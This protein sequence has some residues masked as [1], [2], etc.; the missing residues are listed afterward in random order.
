MTETYTEYGCYIEATTATVLL[1]YS[2]QIGSPSFSFQEITRPSSSATESSTPSAT[3]PPNEDGG[4][5]PVGGIVGGVVGGL[6][7]LGA[8]AFGIVFL[9]LRSRRKAR[10][11][12]A[13]ADPAAAAMMPPQPSPNDYKQPGMM[14]QQDPNPYFPD[15]RQSG[16]MG[17]Y[18]GDPNNLQPQQQY[19]GQPIAQGMPYSPST[20]PAPQYSPGQTHPAPVINQLDSHEIPQHQQPP[21]GANGQRLHEAP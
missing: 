18:G 17:A 20:S 4:G 10:A 1:T 6:A 21:S 7:V 15:P 16:Y 19:P 13:A 12:A 8:L 5:T 14:V 2:G 11:N 9:V 3:D